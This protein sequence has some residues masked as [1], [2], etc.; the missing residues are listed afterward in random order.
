VTKIEEKGE[1]TTLVDKCITRH[2][3]MYFPQ[4]E[5]INDF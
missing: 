3:N 1:K 2:S 5:Y 4:I